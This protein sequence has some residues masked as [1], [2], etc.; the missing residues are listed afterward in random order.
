MLTLQTQLD[1]RN[2]LHPAVQPG[3]KLEH[4]WPDDP[5]YVDFG[6][7]LA[8]ARVDDWKKITQPVARRG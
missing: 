5:V 2:L 8:A 4:T 6:T 7:R 3:A 1:L